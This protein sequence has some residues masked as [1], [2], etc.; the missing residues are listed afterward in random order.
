MSAVQKELIERYEKAY[1]NCYEVE[2]PKNTIETVG[3]FF[4]LHGAYLT[5]DQL[6]H[7]AYRLEC[8]SKR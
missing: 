4:V 7:E 3:V 1:R 5:Y 6:R 2:L 8:R